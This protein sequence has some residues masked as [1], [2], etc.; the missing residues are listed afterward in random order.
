MTDIVPERRNV[1][2]DI[3]TNPARTGI[4]KQHELEWNSHALTLIGMVQAQARN[5]RGR[6]GG[7]VLGY[8]VEVCGCAHPQLITMAMHPFQRSS[9]QGASRRT[10]SALSLRVGGRSFNG[11]R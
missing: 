7:V 6:T 11:I 1:S 5:G 4:Q 3:S 8:A 10:V 9:A 2:T